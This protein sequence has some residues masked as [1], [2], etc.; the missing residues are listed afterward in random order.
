MRSAYCLSLYPPCAALLRV[1]VHLRFA[2]W[3]SVSRPR[4]DATSRLSICQSQWLSC[5]Q[6]WLGLTQYPEN[7]HLCACWPSNRLVKNSVSCCQVG[8]EVYLGM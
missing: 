1:P 4:P 2:S 8:S 5:P 6:Q 3:L 7:V